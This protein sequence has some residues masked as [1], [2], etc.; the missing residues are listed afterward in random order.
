MAPLTIGAW[1]LEVDG[2]AF[3]VLE[4]GYLRA[5]VAFLKRMRYYQPGFSDG[6]Q[7]A[8]DVGAGKDQGDAG[9]GV[10]GEGKDQ[11]RPARLESR[12]PTRVG[13]VLFEPRTSL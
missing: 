9:C 7:A 13:E 2:V 1:L 12:A 4:A 10:G 6:P 8:V 5:P 3:G 11:A